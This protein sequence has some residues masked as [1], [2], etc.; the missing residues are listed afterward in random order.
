[1]SLFKLRQSL[2][3][4]LTAFIWGTAFVAQSV[5]MEYVGPFTFSFVR[6]IIGSVVL[7][8][9]ILFINK[10]ENAGKN[11]EEQ[12]KIL[13]KDTVTGG[14][15]C[16]VILFFAANL[17]QIALQNAGTGKAGFLTAMY[18]IMVPIL[19]LFMHKKTG[20][21]LW[22]GVVIAVIGLYLLC[23][24]DSTGLK[25]EDYLLLLCSFVFSLH[26]ITI[27]FFAPKANCVAM[28][29]IQFLICGLLSGVVMLAVESP[30]VS[31]IM[32]SML[33]ICYA[34]VFSSGVAYTLQIV[35]QKGMNPTVAS[36]LMS[37][38]SVFA[39]LSG[40]VILNQAMNGRELMG[41]V[42]MFAAIILAQLPE[43]AGGN[44]N[45]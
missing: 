33:P 45:G 32:A 21:K 36:L 20:V 30:N 28:S 2:L 18:I 44:K 16:G 29:S 35:G 13:N 27:D 11:D 6:N 31:N 34:G 8:P 22:I 7:I 37:L 25:K 1:M 17:Q 24:T 3:L 12:K 4:L 15:A 5:G 14:L 43:K 38:E 26:I 42:L 10:K 39:L 40:W 41:C 9:V 19:G 23:V